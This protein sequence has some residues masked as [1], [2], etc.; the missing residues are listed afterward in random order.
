MRR[1]SKAEGN[2]ICLG[3]IRLF[4][5]LLMPRVSANRFSI[6]EP[7]VALGSTFGVV[8]ILLAKTLISLGAVFER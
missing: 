4:L 6:L 8:A 2:C 5:L 1:K 3:D 7:P